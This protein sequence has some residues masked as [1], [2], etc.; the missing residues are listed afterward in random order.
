MIRYITGDTSHVYQDEKLK[1][2][3]ITDKCK[4][5]RATMA[6]SNEITQKAE[7]QERKENKPIYE[8]GLEEALENL[9]KHNL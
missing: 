4:Q 5:L 3:A 1:E 6:Q 2:M 7:K 9:R 8:S